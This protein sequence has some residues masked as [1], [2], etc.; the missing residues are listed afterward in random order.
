MG[1]QQGIVVNPTPKSEKS[2][3]KGY[4]PRSGKALFS[5]TSLRERGSSIP[6]RQNGAPNRRHATVNGTA[7]S[8][9]GV[10][11]S[12]LVNGVSETNGEITAER[13]LE[14]CP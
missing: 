11:G 12:Y 8:S 2:A 14:G 7:S 5:S 9:Y 3:K 1:V 13:E 10:R 4:L 6:E